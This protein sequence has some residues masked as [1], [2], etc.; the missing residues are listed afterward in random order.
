MNAKIN[1]TLSDV[2]AYTP[3]GDPKTAIGDTFFSISHRHNN[4][5]SPINHDQHGLTLFTR[6][7]LNLTDSNLLNLRTAIPLLTQDSVSVQRMVRKALDPRINL[8]CPVFDDKCAFIPVLSNLL[9]RLNGWPDPTIESYTSKPGRSGEEFSLVDGYIDNKSAFQL[10]ATFRNMISDPITLV[11]DTWLKYMD[12]VHDGSALLP[13]PDYI[14]MNMLD[15]NTRVYRIVLDRSRRF[16]QKIAACGAMFPVSTT[17]GQSFNYEVDQTRNSANDEIQITFKANG[18]IYNDYILIQNFN[19]V[20]GIFNPDM[21]EHRY[22][23]SM[24]QIEHD[25]LVY[26]KNRGY[27]RIDPNTLELQWWIS[28]DEYNAK[29]RA[30]NRH[31]EALGVDRTFEQADQ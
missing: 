9:L 1:T 21:R 2:L 4:N 28:P 27:P 24:V 31:L 26:F 3:L 25:M 22:A 16:V 29:M 11:F 17:T 30:I 7:Q 8:P 19:N 14:A 12:E 10:T 5:P 13:Y 15:Y 18:W 20:V 6:P 23:N